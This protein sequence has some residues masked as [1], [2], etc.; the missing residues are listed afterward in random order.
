M[1]HRAS[2]LPWPSYDFC[3]DSCF[4]QDLTVGAGAE[5]VVARWNASGRWIERMD[6]GCFRKEIHGSQIFSIEIIFPLAGHNA[7]TSQATVDRSA[8]SVA[9]SCLLWLWFNGG[10]LIFQKFS[11]LWGFPEKALYLLANNLTCTSLAP[12]PWGAM[13]SCMFPEVY[14]SKGQ[15]KGPF[16][17]WWHLPR[18][19]MCKTY[20][21]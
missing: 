6:Y 13:V 10:C 19:S 1:N 18:A 16:W 4:Y 12:K 8:W 5:L 14:F 2:W 11:K 3:G 15:I 7:F 20:S 21:L 9:T 17:S